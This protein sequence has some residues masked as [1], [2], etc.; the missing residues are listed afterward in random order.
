MNCV[1]GARRSAGPGRTG[2]LG[3]RIIGAT[4][5]KLPAQI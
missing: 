2:A 3:K 5:T 4:G 1:R